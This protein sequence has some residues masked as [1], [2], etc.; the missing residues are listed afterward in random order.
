LA[1]A[2]RVAEERKA[3]PKHVK[4]LQ[5]LPAIPCDTNATR[6]RR[7]VRHVFLRY[8]RVPAGLNRS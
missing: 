7:S 1:F 2:V 5:A 4:G 8:E 3:N 6:K